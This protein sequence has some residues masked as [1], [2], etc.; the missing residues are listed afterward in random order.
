MRKKLG[1]RAATEEGAGEVV[2]FVDERGG[3]RLGVVL[4]VRGGDLDVWVPGDFVRRLAR[5][6]VSPADSA[7]PAEVAGV[8]ADARGFGG[9]G[10]GQRVSYGTREGERESEGALVEK[11]RFGA[12]IARPDGSVVGVGFRRVRAA[13]DPTQN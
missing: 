2:R 9:L 12:L 4:F 1:G 6:E 5:G 8:A 13:A 10:E 11:C 7:L 3:E